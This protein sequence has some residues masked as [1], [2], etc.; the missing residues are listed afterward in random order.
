MADI[1]PLTLD[2]EAL[3]AEL[4]STGVRSVE[5]ALGDFTAIARG[6][7]VPTADLISAGGC[8][9][10]SV[11]FGMSTTGGAPMDLFGSVLPK[12]YGDMHALPDLATLAPRPGRRNEATVIC[13]PTGRWFSSRYER[14]VDASELSPRAALRRV[15]AAY[16]SQ[17]LEA[18]VAPELEMF[19]LQREEGGDGIRLCGARARPGAPAREAACEQYSLERLAH[20]EPFFDDLYAAAEALTIPLAGY[21]HEAA[22]TQYEVN[23]YPGKPLAMADAVFRFKRLAREIAARHGFLASFAAKPFLD[24]PGTGMHWHFSVQRSGEAWPHLFATPQGASTSALMHYIAGL[25]SHARGAM[26]IFAPYDMAFDRIVMNDASPTHANWGDDDRHAAF[27]IPASSGPGRRVENRLPGGDANPYLTVAATL[28][29]GLAGLNA[30][31]LPLAGQHEASALPRSL[32][33]ALAALEAD[34]ALRKWLGDPLVDLY[35]AV[36]RHEHAERQALADPRREWDLNHLI[37]L[38]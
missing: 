31:R 19:L 28:A 22:F 13:E 20:F 7:I 9:M 26:A 6:K 4:E 5:C 8:K 35:V 25:Q 21:Q 23:F 29:M 16:E 14:E 37:E 32:P 18:S 38:A 33:E 12:G 24:Q 11:L 36:K 27:R 3:R 15:V 10:P 1:V 30:E 34:G 17:G 2:S